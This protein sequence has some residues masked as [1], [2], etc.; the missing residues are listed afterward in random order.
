MLPPT[1][2][3]VYPDSSFHVTFPNASNSSMK[4]PWCYPAQHN[5]SVLNVVPFLI[6]DTEFIDITLYVLTLYCTAR[7]L[8]KKHTCSYYVIFTGSIRVLGL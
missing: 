3:L 1:Q 4:F 8:R 6:P 5:L 7:S 2:G